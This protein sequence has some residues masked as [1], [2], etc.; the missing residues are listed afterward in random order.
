MG[1]TQEQAYR[2]AS[3]IKPSDVLKYINNHQSEYEEW[4][5]EEQKKVQKEKEELKYEPKICEIERG[6][7]S[8]DK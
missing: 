7:E 4:L 2:L 6:Q 5:N 1:L 8:N 3:M